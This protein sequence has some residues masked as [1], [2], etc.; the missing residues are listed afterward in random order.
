MRKRCESALGIH[1]D[2][3]VREG[4]TVADIY[5]PDI[6]GRMLDRI[7]P[8]FVQCDTKG[9]PGLSSY[10]TEIGNPAPDIR[11]DILKMWR[12]LTAERDIALYAHH[13]GLFDMKA[14]QLHP[15]W[16]VVDEDE[17]VSDSYM[18]VFGPYADEL[19]I[20]QIKEM[21][22]KYALDG[23][24]V[25]GECWGAYI[26]YSDHAKKA[27]F[28]ATGKRLP[29]SDDPDFENF[30]EFNRQG[31]LNYVTHYISE[32]KREYPDF[33][34]TSNWIFSEY[35]NESIK[36]PIDFLS[37]DYDC[38]NSVNSARHHGRTL[39]SH[40]FSW[41]L[42][43]W[44]QNTLVCDW[45]E[46]DRQNKE[47]EQLMQEAA[48]VVAL[49]GCFDFFNILYGHGSH[50]QEWC[51][52]GWGRVADFV[53]ERQNHC[54]RSEPV[55][56]IAYI[57]GRT[58]PDNIRM[59]DITPDCTNMQNTLLMLQD[60]QY[61]TEVLFDDSLDRLSNF[62][63]AFLPGTVHLTDIAVEDIE[64]FVYSGGNVVVDFPCVHYFKNIVSFPSSERSL[65]YVYGN[66]RLA[67]M[68][69][70]CVR[71]SDGGGAFYEDN[72][73]ESQK[74]SSYKKVKY[75]NG[76]F[77]FNCFDITSASV[78][79]VSAPFISYIKD[80]VSETGFVPMVRIINN[81]WVD[82]TIM[83]K[84]GKLLVNLINMCGNH[85]VKSVR[86]FSQVPSLCD[87]DMEIDY[88][89]MPESVFIEPGHIKCDFTY[90]DNTIKL[91]V[92]RLHIHNVIEIY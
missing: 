51:I 4:M 13:S 49:G 62:K 60:A 76:Y 79:N 71:I 87:I 38:A 44:G 37:G 35:M 42:I 74:W 88:P 29:G 91:T 18:S 48:V 24:W 17:N 61:S 77:V 68:Q 56:Q 26:D 72:F 58:Y 36:V 25:D 43:A 69:T 7:K 64:N 33:Q 78:V 80:I 54:F 57:F 67:A 32:V 73:Y 83:Q 85:N 20:P 90:E 41:D 22:G 34:I 45:K 47:P 5:R 46:V 40:G 9:H 75:G 66:G 86:S 1:F 19:L 23:V 31:F 6:I 16:A 82:V 53:R 2:F 84:D 59:Y 10:P 15:E 3:H 50:I 14:A 11:H 27:Y 63:V 21:A 65:I 12:N 70:K 30:K 81:S 89:H 8:D 52:E 55:H 92:D 39:L 28:D